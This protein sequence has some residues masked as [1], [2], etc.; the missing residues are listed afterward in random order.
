MAY[1]VP[2]AMSRRSSFSSEILLRPSS[3][4]S[5]GSPASPDLT[6]THNYSRS[7]T[8]SSI[9]SEGFRN[10]INSNRNS[11]TGSVVLANSSSDQTT[12]L[13]APSSPPISI[14]EHQQPG[15]VLPE[16]VASVDTP[17]NKVLSERIANQP[18]VNRPPD[19]AKDAAKKAT[20]IPRLVTSAT[21]PTRDHEELALQLSENPAQPPSNV[22]AGN[23]RFI[24]RP[25]TRQ[26]R[27]VGSQMSLR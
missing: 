1:R 22:A 17:L 18:M 3:R 20:R 16:Q 19:G 15:N 24:S 8:I 5:D 7:E 2:R 13:H 9:T 6:V 4:G 27:P 10:M 21:A 26:V 25:A 12:L 11:W 14:S 23:N